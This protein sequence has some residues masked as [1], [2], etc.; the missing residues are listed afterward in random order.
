MKSSCKYDYKLREKH[1]FFKFFD[2]LYASDNF[3]FNYVCKFLTQKDYMIKHNFNST[4]A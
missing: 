2:I 4:N 3:L 1:F